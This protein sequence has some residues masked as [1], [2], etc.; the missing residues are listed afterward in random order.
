VAYTDHVLVAFG[1][2]WDNETSEIWESTV[3]MSADGG[4]GVT[5]D[6]DA[7]LAAV[8]APLFNWFGMGS[9]GM[10]SHA[11]LKWLKCNHVG[12]DGK[13]TDTG[14]T[15]VHDYSPTTTGGVPQTGPGYC[16]LAYT[17]E[18]AVV[19]GPGHR[20]RIYPPNATYALA[21][22]FRVSSA[23]RNL[24]AA[25]GEALLHIF[26]NSAGAAG[27]KGTPVIASK[28]GGAI[29]DITGV[30]CDDVYDVQRRRKNRVKPAR[31][32]VVAL[33]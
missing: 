5:L 26:R 16:T 23:D 30:T 13:Y 15:H 1:G 32:P 19:R 4:G 14:I 9:A 28:I 6:P 11:T 31:S 8:A 21:T 10:S 24:A 22:P 7:W 29:H 17:W 2:S 12:A 33:V 3:R 18:T 27:S 20:G 25:A